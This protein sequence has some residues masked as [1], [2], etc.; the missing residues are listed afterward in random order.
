MTTREQIVNRQI[1]RWWE[2]QRALAAERAS[3]KRAPAARPVVTVSRQAG[4]GGTM[5]AE[6][7]SRRLGY[8]L[9]D[10]ELIHAMSQLAGV[11]EDIVRSLDEH[12]G[13]G[14]DLWVDGVIRG[15][16]FDNSDY[17]RTLMRIVYLIAGHGAAVIVGRGANFILEGESVFHARI[18]AP[19]AERQTRL[20]RAYGL[21]AAE[22]E[23]HL[24]RIDHNQADFVRQHFRRDIDD[25]A[26]YHL[27]VN[28]GAIPPEATAEVILEAL[29]RLGWGKRTSAAQ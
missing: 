27:V 22:A 11:H 28:T 14:V 7:V 21:A 2:E 1:R 20:M 16:Q 26:A 18:I 5:V 8:D 13:S 24:H 6:L 3:S 9:F 25:P 29:S 17:L 10:R 4:S 12:R 19:H 23:E 15:R